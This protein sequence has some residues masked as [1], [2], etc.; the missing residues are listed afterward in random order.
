M[1]KIVYMIHDKETG[2][3][4]GV[5]CR[6]YHDDFE[7]SSKERALNANCHGIHKDTEKYEVKKYRV[8]YE[9]IEDNGS[10]R[11]SNRDLYHNHR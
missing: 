8:T 10:I 2:E 9:E 6:A 5:Y 7:F 4:Q 11:E 3:A 1:Q